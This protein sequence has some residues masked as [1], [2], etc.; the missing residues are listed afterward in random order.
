ML[1]RLS[2]RLALT[3]EGHNRDLDCRKGHQTVKETAEVA[4][5]WQGNLERNELSSG[6]T[7]RMYKSCVVVVWMGMN[8]ESPVLPYRTFSHR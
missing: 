5:E 3:K 4:V 7:S 6:L 2:Y 1:P 8:E